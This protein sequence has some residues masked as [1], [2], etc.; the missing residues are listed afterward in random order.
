M[1]A[2]YRYSSAMSCIGQSEAN[3]SSTMP[4]A[5]ASLLVRVSTGVPACTTFGPMVRA[6]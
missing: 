5:K 4:P 3:H 6:A 2:K 1:W